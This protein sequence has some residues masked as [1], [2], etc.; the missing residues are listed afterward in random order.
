MLRNVTKEDT[1][2][3][4]LAI[5]DQMV[6]GARSALL[7][8]PGVSQA[9]APTVNG[10]SA[11]LFHFGS[12]CTV[13]H[14]AIASVLHTSTS[15]AMLTSPRRLIHTQ[16]SPGELL[17]L[18]LAVHHQGLAY[19]SLHNLM[20]LCG[21]SLVCSVAMKRAGLCVWRRMLQRTDWY[22]QEKAATLLTAIL[23]ARPNRGTAETPLPPLVMNGSSSSSTHHAPPPV[24]TPTAES[25]AVQN[26]LVTFVDWLTSQLRCG[27]LPT[28]HSR[29]KDVAVRYQSKSPARCNNCCCK[30]SCVC[31]AG[32]YRH[33]QGLGA[34]SSSSQG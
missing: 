17:A 9:N 25:E 15:R 6:E 5:L 14:Q 32:T 29:A 13:A 11:I 20:Q 1:V 21:I 28:R 8:F 27:L 33:L 12:C 4:V 34:H 26:I 3:Y 7:P 18:Q 19:C 10:L 16:S 31:M 22:T 30:V 23:A 2:Q 24:P